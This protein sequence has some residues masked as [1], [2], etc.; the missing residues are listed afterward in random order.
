VHRFQV[1]WHDVRVETEDPA[2]FACIGLMVQQATQHL[3]LQ[4]RV[5]LAVRGAAGAGYQIFDGGDLCA[6]AETPEE[7]LDIVYMRVNRRAMELASL[8]GWVRMHGAVAGLGGHRVAVVGAGASGKTTLAVGLLCDGVNV[9]AD[10]SFL[11]RD[12][13][14]L[15]VPRRLHV[16]PGTVAFVSAAPW[17][18]DAPELGPLPIR[19]VDPTEHG[20][21]WDLPIGPIQDLILLQ[22]TD[23]PSR[24]EPLP[25]S[26]AVQE[27]MGQVFPVLEPR[28]VIVRQ[29][30]QLASFARCHALHAG[31]DGAA[32]GLVKVLVTSAG[33]P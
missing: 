20:F 3:A 9:E 32:P 22:R 11:A 14:V 5:R 21:A 19:V 16:K 28:R 33:L 30:A 29:A 26:R 6:T 15:G 2:V 8:K 25:A 4:A 13:D 10:E 7:V 24:L 27:I 12:G 1:L 17:L 18:L 23:G 31:P